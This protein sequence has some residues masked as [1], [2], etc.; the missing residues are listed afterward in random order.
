MATYSI[1]HHW[2]E[3][4]SKAVMKGLADFNLPFIGTDQQQ[5]LAIIVRDEG[6]V[7]AGLLAETKW[8]WMY[9]GWVW[10]R[11]DHRTNGI[12]TRMMRD[13]ELQ[14][15]AMGCDHAHLTT[16]DFQ[17][18]GFYERLGYEVFAALKDYPRGH[19]RFMMKKNIPEKP[20]R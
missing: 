15:R 13:A 3:D 5:R 1:E 14:A 8:N 4:A 7:V 16:L 19:T 12:G 11:E 9:I 18:K 17:A 2:D 20:L 10:V 6:E